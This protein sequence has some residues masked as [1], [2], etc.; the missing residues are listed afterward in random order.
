MTELTD[1]ERILILEFQVKSLRRE[2]KRRRDRDRWVIG[3]LI[4]I[5]A[6]MVTVI[7]PF[8]VVKGGM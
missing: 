2:M 5:A 7:L 1:H 8:V 6:L 3:T 4:A